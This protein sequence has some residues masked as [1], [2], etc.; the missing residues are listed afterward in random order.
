ML[1]FGVLCSGLGSKPQTLTQIPQNKVVLVITTRPQGSIRAW[2]FVFGVG[3]GAQPGPG[4]SLAV[5]LRQLQGPDAKSTRVE[6]ATHAPQ[7][8]ITMF[9]SLG[10]KKSC[11]A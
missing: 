9:E 7:L 6:A 2:S 10:E 4:G 1:G 3:G 5:A 8:K 11:P